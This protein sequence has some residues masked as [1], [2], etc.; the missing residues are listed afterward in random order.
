MKR[1][2]AIKQKIATNIQKEKQ[3]KVTKTRMMRL[4]AKIHIKEGHGA[5]KERKG[6]DK[7]SNCKQASA[8]TMDL[9]ALLDFLDD[10][11]E[12]DDYEPPVTQR[13]T[14]K[15]IPL[16][17]DDDDD[18]DENEEGENDDGDDDDNEEE[19]EEITLQAGKA[20]QRKHS[21]PVAVAK[22]K[23]VSEDVITEERRMAGQCCANVSQATEFCKYICDVMK[24]FEE[25]VKKGKQVKKYL[26]EMIEDVRE[27]CANIRYLGM[28]FDPEE[29]VPTFLIPH[30]RCGEQ[31]SVEVNLW[32]GMTLKR[33]TLDTIRIWSLQTDVIKMWDI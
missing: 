24:T 26:L 32:T 9:F 31:N 15:V 17:E 27:A 22:S 20:E 7:A 5:R 25:H 14:G 10:D 16:F 23:H 28:D 30:S 13:R 12:D 18:D 1:P 4:I 3:M 2:M 19:D 8:D 33:Q 11:E 6:S 29:I 21:K